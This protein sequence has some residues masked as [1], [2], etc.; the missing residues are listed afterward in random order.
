[1]YL[2]YSLEIRKYFFY[3]LLFKKLYYGSIMIIEPILV[4][5]LPNQKRKGRII[6]RRVRQRHSNCSTPSQTRCSLWRDGSC[7]FIFAI[8]QIWKPVSNDLYLAKSNHRRREETLCF[9]SYPYGPCK[10]ET[11]WWKSKE[12]TRSRR[13]CQT[14]C[15]KKEINFFWGITPPIGLKN[16]TF[17]F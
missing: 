9:P 7:K 1:M 3:V 11:R 17:S 13:G 14:S 10:Q 12:S 16:R 6:C 4:D 5:Y 15:P 2:L 8:F